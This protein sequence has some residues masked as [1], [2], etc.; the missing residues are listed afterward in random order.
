MNPHSVTKH[1]FA[2][3]MAQVGFTLGMM[4]WGICDGGA[5]GVA[6]F[7][8][9]VLCWGVLLATS[10]GA[11]LCSHYGYFVVGSA[12]GRWGPWRLWG[13]VGVW[14]HLRQWQV[15]LVA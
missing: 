15:N 12:M 11:V 14:V 7:S 1:R 4:V 6:E 13:R 10:I 8:F 5:V 9:V 3:F 2:R